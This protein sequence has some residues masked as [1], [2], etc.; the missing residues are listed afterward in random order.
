MRN[1]SKA[2]A[3][4]FAFSLAL[5]AAGFGV[6]L[7]NASGMRV[8]DYGL[9]ALFVIAYALVDAMSVRL[10]RGDTVFVDG[11][12]ALAS[13]ILLPPSQAVVCCVLGVSLG[14]PFDTRNHK[15]LLTRLGEILRRPLLVATIALLSGQVL[16]RQA[17]AAGSTIA[18]LWA[19]GLGTVHSVTD[20]WLLV[21]GV[22]LEKHQSVLSS[23]SGLSR[24]LAALYAAHV[25][26]GVV[27][28][29]LYPS[30]RLWGLGI[31]ILLVLMIQYSFNLL[32]KTKGAYGET[33]Q[34][35]VR[36]SELQSGVGEEGHAQRVADACVNAG[37]LLGLSSKALERL[38]YAALLHE[39]GRIGIDEGVG[40]SDAKAS[41]PQ[42]G[43]DIVGGIPFLASTRA[44]I[45][46]QGVAPT[47]GRLQADDEDALCAQLIG[48]CCALDRFVV[49][50][51]GRR[52]DGKS[53]ASGLDS[54]APLIDARV[55]SAVRSAFT[56]GLLS[57][58]RTA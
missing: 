55:R 7:A 40:S 29:L 14:A 52:L 51:P 39:I 36:A 3:G 30:G 41:H 35:L 21:L 23:I 56:R 4:H 53:V 9:A 5:A 20:F 6:V 38:N 25:S 17:L 31:T 57:K 37:R 18:I 12:I 1:Q 24:S 43:A 48:V 32:L 15:P 16:D 10:S 49:L 26:L 45:R 2:E 13:V 22:S 19:V 50:S 27:A 44:M 58:E 33:I 47:A 11:A 54:C 34:A 28:A 8:V 46:D 42:R